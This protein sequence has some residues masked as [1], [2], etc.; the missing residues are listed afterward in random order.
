MKP[1]EQ[2]PFWATG[3]SVIDA[4]RRAFKELERKRLRIARLDVDCPAWKRLYIEIRELEAFLKLAPT[5]NGVG[6]RRE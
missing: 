4:E 1:W 5:I 3:P 2:P 6:M